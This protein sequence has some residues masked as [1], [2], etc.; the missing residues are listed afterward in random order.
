MNNELFTK[1]ILIIIAFIFMLIAI[2]YLSYY[3]YFIKLQAFVIK[4]NPKLPA[5][6]LFIIASG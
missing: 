1:M 3:N 4:S 6:G 2:S 5:W